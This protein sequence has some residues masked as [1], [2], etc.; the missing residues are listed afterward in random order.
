MIVDVH[1]HCIQPEHTAESSRLAM[2]RAG[3]PPMQPLLFEDFRRDMEVVDR[4]IVFGV[5]A[6]ASGNI[7]PDEYTAE[8]V[9]NDPE[10]LIGFAAVD[11]TEDDYLERM[12]RAAT[13]LGLR[14]FKIYPMLAR[15]NPADPTVFPMYAM[16]E[17]L[18]LPI[19]SHTGAHPGPRAILKYSQPLLFDEV[20][21]AFP[22]V[23]I[24]M[25]HMSHPWQRDCAVVLRKHP[26]LYADVSGAGWVR[27][28]QAWEGLILMQEWGVGDK[29]LFGSD[30]PNWTPKQGM[31]EMR[32]LNELVEGTNLPTISEELIEGIFTRDSLALLGIE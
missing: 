9:S 6:V 27:P 1:T 5:R 11:P 10:K 2:E 21:Q 13:E 23:K 8:W 14:G 17:R 28:W 31:E 26:N 19:L 22:N 18:G 15:F 12:E 24:V 7:S 20:A 16:A 30:Y 3:Y 25:A 4:A 32:A 29:L